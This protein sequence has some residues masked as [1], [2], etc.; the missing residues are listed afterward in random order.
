MKIHFI[1]FGAG[2]INYYNAV[3]RICHQAQQFNMFKT[4]YG[5]TDENLKHDEEFKDFWSKHGDFITKN[6]RGFGYWIWKMVIILNVMS[7]ENIAEGDIILFAD[8]G[9][10]LNIRGRH[11]MLEY[12]K[13]VMTHDILAF[14]MDH[15]VEKKWTKID[16]LEH[17]N[18]SDEDRN[19]GQIIGTTLFMKKTSKNIEILKEV[20]ELTLHDNYRLVNDSP[21]VFPN[22]SVFIEH[23][24]DQSCLSITLKKHKAFTLSDETY[25]PNWSDGLMYPI[26]AMRNRTGYT[27]L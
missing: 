7:R 11:K 20:I 19:S 18:V 8:A 27:Y 17:A 14:R 2:N 25:F 16:L 6:P 24:H 21:C 4:I 15:H 22:D 9:C 23:R 1:T 3:R 26:L 13:H 5:F 10:E 12:I